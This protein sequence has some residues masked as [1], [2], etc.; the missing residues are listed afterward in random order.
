MALHAAPSLRQMRAV[1]H[2]VSG[3]RPSAAPRRLSSVAASGRHGQTAASLRP[4]RNLSSIV[5][6]PSHVASLKPTTAQQ[7]RSVSADVAVPAEQGSAAAPAKEE[8]TFKLV[9]FYAFPKGG[10][11]DPR[12]EVEVHKEFCKASWDPKT[13]FIFSASLGSP[14]LCLYLLVCTDAEP[15]LLCRQARDIKGRIYMNEQG[16]NAQLSGS[17][18]AAIEYANFVI[19]R[20]PRFEGTRV[21]PG[22]RSSALVAIILAHSAFPQRTSAPR[23]PAIRSPRSLAHRPP[24]TSPVAS[25][26]APGG[27][28]FRLIASYSAYLRAGQRV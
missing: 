19:A 24:T 26:S 4:L 10:I 27:L 16:I 5:P 7:R 1:W 18:D 28:Q 25:H 8:T 2:L 13:H 6:A 15:A 17:G 9:T 14:R 22:T 12:S 23:G 11:A 21:R 20:D 3:T